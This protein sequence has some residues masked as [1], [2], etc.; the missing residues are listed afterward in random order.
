MKPSKKHLRVLVTGAS[1]T[2]GRQVVTQLIGEQKIDVVVFDRETRDARRFFHQF[3]GR[4]QVYFGDIGN[5]KEVLPACKNLDAVIHLAALIPP[6]A[7][8]KPGLAKRVNVTGTVNLVQALN[9]Y[10][11]EVF[12]LY[13][14]SISVYGDRLQNPWIKTDDKLVPCERDYYAKTKLEAEKL[15]QE[16]VAHWTIFRL[17]AI[18]GPG[19]HGASPLM[20][21]M[22]LETKLEIC[23]PEDA[24]RAFVLALDY[25][26]ELG[27]RIFNLGGGPSCRMTY[28]EFIKR[29]FAIS[30]LGRPDFKPG[31]FAEKNFHCGYYADGD[32][33]EDTLHFRRH[34][35][36]DYFE[37]LKRSISPFRKSLTRMLR[38]FIIKRLQNMSE[39]YRA[40]RENNRE[41]MAYFFQSTNP[42]S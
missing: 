20:F 39:P 36:D 32:K 1:G 16:N 37:A 8:E 17:T 42:K 24:A 31:S 28:R 18:M 27:H 25:Q 13:S 40:F 23:T 26:K 5:K 9:F 6:E 19:N 22:P 38:P 33:L 4:L 30:G 2:V 29:S 12:F 7:D 21:H 10:S 41:D 14:S 34:S 35:A 15:I 11:P 3:S